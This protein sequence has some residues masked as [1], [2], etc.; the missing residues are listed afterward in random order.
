MK[1][2]HN[3]LV[4]KFFNGTCTPDEAEQVLD[5]LETPE[6]QEFLDV[7]LENDIKEW[8]EE[9]KPVED[10][11]KK[12]KTR[13]GDALDS[14][15]LFRRI[16]DSL[17]WSRTPRRRSFLNPLFQVAALLCVI[18]TASLFYF[19]SEKSSL[20]EMADV[21][22]VFST[23]D[24]QQKQITLRDGSVVWLNSRSELRIAG[25]FNSDK[26]TVALI[27]EAFFDVAH[28]PD[29]PFIIHAGAS[30]IEVLGTSF[31]VKLTDTQTNVGVAVSEG[32]VRL[33]HADVK[34]FSQFVEL[35][36][37]HY[38]ELNTE[39]GQVLTDVNGIENYISWKNGRLVFESMSLE[40]VCLQ[41]GRIY[42][43]TCSFGDSTIK[44]RAPSTNFS[45]EGIDKTLSVIGLSLNLRYEK[46]AELIHWLNKK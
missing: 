37:G 42:G 18:S 26:R 15:M 10:P 16:I 44:N 41:L 2:F 36:R 11:S 34:K 29:K 46:E 45:S 30:K 1:T 28:Q 40:E 12:G 32:K 43:T 21:S 24:D 20:E 8:D 4:E 9:K 25:D 7:R 19:Y 23:L 38:G 14:E 27:G 31:N 3:Q 33:S 6:G 22:V 5:W 13:F 35:E 39:S 17:G